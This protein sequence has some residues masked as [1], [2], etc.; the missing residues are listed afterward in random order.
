MNIDKNYKYK[1]GGVSVNGDKLLP[2][3]KKI[4][5]TLTMRG[6]NKFCQEFGIDPNTYEVN[7]EK[8]MDR[9]QQMAI[10][11]NASPELIDALNI[12]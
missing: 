4:L 5:D 6:F 8:F 10:Q 7:K 11:Q 2:L 1:V 3:Y 12:D 9:L